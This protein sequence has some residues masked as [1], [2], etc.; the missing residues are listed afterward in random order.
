[1]K[2][3]HHQPEF[4]KL[5]IPVRLLL[6]RPAEDL[7][8]LAEHQTGGYADLSRMACRASATVIISV[9]GSTGEA[10]NPHLS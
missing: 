1:M 4:R 9:I 7:V 3:Y 2:T 6:L 5:R 8:D 10:M